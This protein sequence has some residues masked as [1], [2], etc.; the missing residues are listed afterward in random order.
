MPLYIF[1][2]TVDSIF[3]LFKEG[4]NALNL[5]DWFCNLTS[6]SYYG[7]GGY[8]RDW[9]LSSLLLLY[10]IYPVLMLYVNKCKRGDLFTPI[11]SACCQYD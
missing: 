10:V 6:L 11:I 8:V 9:Y 7:A 2:A 5:W 1:A 4:K 3:F